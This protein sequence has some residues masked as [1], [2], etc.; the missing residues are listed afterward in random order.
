VRHGPAG[1]AHVSYISHISAIGDASTAFSRRSGQPTAGLIATCEVVT[2]D[3]PERMVGEAASSD[4]TGESQAEL[5]YR[6][7]E[8]AI[9]RLALAPGARVTEQELAQ[10]V[11]L[12][13]TPVRE[14]VLRLVAEGLIEVFPRRGMAVAAINP[15]DVIQ[16]L[17]VRAVLERLVAAA[18]ARRVSPSAR[19]GLQR[20]ADGLLAAAAAGDTARYMHF[21]RAFDAALGEASGNPY[22]VR[23]LAPLQTMARRAWFY[24]RRDLDLQATAARHAAVLQA[25]AAGDPEAAGLASDALV[26]HVREGLKQSLAAL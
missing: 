16:A 6:R 21:D 22:A 8:D 11:A 3:N 17:D 24:F 19:A 5:A 9:V 4:A 12:G 10:R 14:A 25:V 23:A 20:I 13:R 26:A 15:L 1:L 18:A 2:M 7:I